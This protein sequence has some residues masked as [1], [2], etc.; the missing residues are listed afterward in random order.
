MEDRRRRISRWVDE[1]GPRAIGLARTLTDSEDEA[2]DLVQEVWL[3]VLDHDGPLPRSD[4][5]ARAWIFEILRKLAAGRLRTADRRS[6]LL[7]RFRSDVPTGAKAD[8]AG[9]DERAL[10]RE[11][12]A[13][14]DEL[15]T[16][17]RLVLVA[18]L[19][20]G[21][22]VRETAEQ[23]DRA[24]GTVKASLSRAVRT[25]KTS[26]GTDLEDALRRTPVTRRRPPP[27]PDDDDPEGDRDAAVPIR[28]DTGEPT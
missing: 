12:L 7:A 17:Q 3:V 14:I 25:L 24:E 26:L 22:T 13:S 19:V 18:R 27:G 16:L 2:R 21:R 15:P 5:A 6:G 11:V 4:W 9:L 10:L 28:P 23:L 8:G 20:E 1:I